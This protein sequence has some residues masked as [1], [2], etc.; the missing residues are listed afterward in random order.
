M[1]T[2]H[3]RAF[4]VIF[5]ISGALRT[6]SIY[7]L[8]YSPLKNGLITL[9]Y[10]VLIQAGSGCRHWTGTFHRQCRAIHACWLRIRL[11]WPYQLL[12]LCMHMCFGLCH[13]PHIGP[14]LHSV[15]RRQLCHVRHVASTT[16][17]LQCLLPGDS[18]QG[19]REK[20]MQCQAA[21]TILCCADS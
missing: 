21:K 10:P 14:A 4:Y 12:L 2:L 20:G 5:V 13:S 9:I 7:C 6:A 8:K 1:Q 18:D 15:L 17:R 19:I 16:R 3:Y 11:R